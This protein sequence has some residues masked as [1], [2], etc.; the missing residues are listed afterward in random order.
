MKTSLV[1]RRRKVRDYFRKLCVNRYVLSVTQYARLTRCPPEQALLELL[2][3]AKEEPAL[4][5]IRRHETSREIDALS[6]DR[7]LSEL[8]IARA[9]DQHDEQEA[10]VADVQRPG[11]PNGASAL[12][13]SAC[14]DAVTVQGTYMREFRSTCGNYGCVLTWP[15][16]LGEAQATRLVAYR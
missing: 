15:K 7:P 10:E 14:E 3:W 16:G 12:H 13:L 1:Q 11:D 5:P 2:L 4:T 6:C 9:N 8:R